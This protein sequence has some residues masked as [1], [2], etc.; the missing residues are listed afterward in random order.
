MSNLYALGLK[1]WVEIR[2]ARR[3]PQP[4]LSKVKLATPTD[5]VGWSHPYDGRYIPPHSW[6]RQIC[7]K[8]GRFVRSM[9]KR[10]FSALT[11]LKVPIGGVVLIPSSFH[12]Q[13]LEGI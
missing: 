10:R 13:L 9:R 5:S 6:I 3:P 2:K 4:H 7:F 1:G 12:A 8:G 11:S